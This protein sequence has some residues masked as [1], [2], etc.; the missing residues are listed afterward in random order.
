MLPVYSHPISDDD[1]LDDI[2]QDDSLLIKGRYHVKRS[3][4]IRY[5]RN[6]FFCFAI[7]WIIALV[8]VIFAAHIG[9]NVR[10]ELWL[11]AK[12]KLAYHNIITIDFDKVDKPDVKPPTTKQ[13]GGP[14]LCSLQD[15]KNALARRERKVYESE[16]DGSHTK[17]PKRCAIP[18]NDKC[19]LECDKGFEVEDDGYGWAYCDSE[20]KVSIRLSRCLEEMTIKDKIFSAAAAIGAAAAG[21]GIAHHFGQS[22]GTSMGTAVAAAPVAAATPATPAPATAAAPAPVPTP[23]PAPAPAPAPVPVPAPSA[24]SPSIARA[25]APSALATARA[26]ARAKARARERA[27]ASEPKSAPQDG[28]QLPQAPQPLAPKEPTVA[29]PVAASATAQ[30]PVPQEQVQLSKEPASVPQ[31]VQQQLPPAPNQHEGPGN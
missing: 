12:M 22:G 9:E 24:P 2:L 20:G 29:I 25:K 14:K 21:V 28:V 23:V 18:F 13:L 19:R 10:H 30:W 26:K 11:K 5:L 15:V 16:D 6:S 31:D 17:I 3:S 27:S 7:S 8:M 1:D 4:T